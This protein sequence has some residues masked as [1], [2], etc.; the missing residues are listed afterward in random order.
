MHQKL[1]DVIKLISERKEYGEIEMAIAYETLDTD[2]FSVLQE[3][4]KEGLHMRSDQ[5][6]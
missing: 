1:W 5:W 2:A 6:I 3:K 4:F